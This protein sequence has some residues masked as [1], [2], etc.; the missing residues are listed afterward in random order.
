MPFPLHR[1]EQQSSFVVHI[2]PD[3]THCGVGA[4]VGSGVG[5]SVGAGLVGL[6]GAGVGCGVGVGIESQTVQSSSPMEGFV[7]EMGGPSVTFIQAIEPS[8]EGNE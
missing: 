2:P 5:G 3:P 8:E 6:T 7:F 1:R 4:G